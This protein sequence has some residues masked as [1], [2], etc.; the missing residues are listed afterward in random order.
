MKIEPYKII[1]DL[2]TENAHR[3]SVVINKNHP[4]WGAK[5]FNYDFSTDKY[6]TVG[7][8]S[9]SFLLF[10]HNFKFWGVAAFSDVESSSEGNSK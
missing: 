6:H 3:V 10:E 8:G 1:K 2:T 9:N 5:R 7:E 4:E